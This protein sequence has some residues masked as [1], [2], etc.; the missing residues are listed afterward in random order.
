MAEK[1]D[2]KK[3]EAKSGSGKVRDL[4]LLGAILQ[5]SPIPAFAIN[6]QHKVIFWN[7][8]LEELTGIKAAEML[9]T[10]EY[11]RL[12]FQEKQELMADLLI[13]GRADQA[14]HSHPLMFRKSKLI[15]EAYEA[16]NFFPDIGKS[17]KWLRVHG[18][19]VEE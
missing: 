5:G 17:G 1:I 4:Q 2:T 7:R 15:S 19:P 6:R 14:I 9:G 16:T 12:F 18:F 3:R 11:W 10:G 13:D 8:A